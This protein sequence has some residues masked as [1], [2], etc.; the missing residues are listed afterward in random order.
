L[1]A[2]KYRA[3]SRTISPTAVAFRASE[4]KAAMS[5]LEGEDTQ[6]TFDA[7]NCS[8]A[9]GSRTILDVIDAQAEPV[10]QAVGG[11]H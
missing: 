5:E 10:Q 9:D 2:S 8:T 7:L 3:K 6:A 1:P 11:G 4:I